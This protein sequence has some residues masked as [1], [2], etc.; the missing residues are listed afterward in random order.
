M[1]FATDGTIVNDPFGTLTVTS[2]SSVC[3]SDSGSSFS[4]PA[5]PQSEWRRN[6][7]NSAFPWKCDLKSIPRCS[8]AWVTRRRH[9]AGLHQ[10]HRFWGFWMDSLVWFDFR[11]FTYL[12]LLWF[13]PNICSASLW[14]SLVIVDASYLQ[15]MDPF[16]EKAE[17]WFKVN[18]EESSG[19]QPWFDDSICSFQWNVFC[20]W[21]VIRYVTRIIS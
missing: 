12:S 20:Y 14:I 15:D 6:D 21:A 17:S 7:G 13:G 11:V 9:G 2:E 3:R 4:P 10:V 5:E 16:S 8:A 1:W 18:H 19:N